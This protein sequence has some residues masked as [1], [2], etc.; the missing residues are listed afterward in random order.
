MR[1]NGCHSIFNKYTIL[2][3][4]SISCLFNLIPNNYNNYKKECHTKNNKKKENK[5]KNNNDAAAAAA[6]A[7]ADDDNTETTTTMKKMMMT[8]VT[9]KE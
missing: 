7:A 8:S 4:E 1:F 6:A 5:N 2:L 3:I 9:R